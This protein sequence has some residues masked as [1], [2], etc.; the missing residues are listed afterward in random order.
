MVIGYV[1]LHS[2]RIDGMNLR[3]VGGSL[4]AGALAF[5]VV[6]VGL[7]AA[8]DPYVWPSALVSL[9]IAVVLG[10][11]TAVLTSATLAYRAARA[12]DGAGTHRPD[13][14]RARTRMFAVLAAVVAFLVAGVIAAALAGTVLTFSYLAAVL[15][16]GFPVGLLAAV[17]AG[18]ATVFRRSRGAGETPPAA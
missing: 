3:R 5:L 13:A 14:D 16:V 2:R 7:T 9:P 10:G 18:V 17:L 6:F 1:F 4:L 12:A 15:F 8:L 11:L